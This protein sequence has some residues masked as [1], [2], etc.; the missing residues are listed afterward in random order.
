MDLNWVRLQG[1]KRLVSATLN[2]SGKVVAIVGSN[3][4]GKSSIL[5][6]LQH[7]DNNI[8]FNP[9]ELNHGNEFPNDEDVVIEAGFLLD[10]NDRKAIS[11]LFQ[12]NE[13]RLFKI[14]KLFNGTRKWEITPEPNRMAKQ[15][16]GEAKNLSELSKELTDPYNLH[17][18]G[19]K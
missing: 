5:Q 14:I 18:A 12:G 11:H 16:D 7:L 17:S 19:Q 2:T 3:E 13:V 1:Y 10:N 15:Y 9:Q 6:A 8:R 4:A